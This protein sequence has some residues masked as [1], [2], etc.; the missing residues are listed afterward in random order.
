METHLPCYQPR[1]C[2]HTPQDDSDT[3]QGSSYRNGTGL[4]CSSFWGAFGSKWH[5]RE[6]KGESGW[7]ARQAEPS[8]S[9][10]L[11]AV[12]Q[13][14]A[15]C[16]PLSRQGLLLYFIKT[17]VTGTLRPP[18][19]GSSIFSRP[20]K[21]PNVGYYYESQECTLAAQVYRESTGKTCTL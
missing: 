5:L 7:G 13:R 21:F 11:D 20:I 14:G 3:P 15:V 8:V 16:T 19:K 6:G 18:G 9:P 4:A 1:K 12:R 2:P 17:E 10:P